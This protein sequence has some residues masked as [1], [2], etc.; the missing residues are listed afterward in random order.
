MPEK[1]LCF[2]DTWYL[3]FYVDGCL[4]CR[5]FHSTLHTRQSSKLALFTRQVHILPKTP[6]QFSKTPTHTHTHTLQNPHIPTHYKTPLLPMLIYD[7]NMLFLCVWLPL[8]LFL[9]FSKS[10][11]IRACT[12][13][14]MSQCNLSLASLLSSSFAKLFHCAGYF[15]HN[16]LSW[17]N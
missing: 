4:V 2:Y 10:F 11:R 16:N 6:S 14:L 15:M 3:L 1:Q 13:T 17:N 9:F 12:L 7:Y 8:R 5:A